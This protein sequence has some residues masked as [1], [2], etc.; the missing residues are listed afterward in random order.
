MGSS[1]K[2]ATNP[3][4]PDAVTVGINDMSQYLGQNDKALTVA[5]YV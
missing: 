4:L 1:S 3:F 2:P 5:C